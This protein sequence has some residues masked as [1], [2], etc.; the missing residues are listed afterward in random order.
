ETPPK[1]VNERSARIYAQGHPYSVTLAASGPS[2]LS[3]AERSVWA[4]A[5]YA[6]SPALLK[7]L[8]NKSQ[9]DV[10]KV[11]NETGGLPLRAPR[12]T[13]SWGRDRF[14][15]DLGEYPPEQFAKRSERTLQLAALEVQRRAFLAKRERERARWVDPDTKEVVAVS[16]EEIEE[17]RLR[18]SEIA[19]LRMELY[20]E[21]SGAYG[22]DPDWDDVVPMPVEDGEG[23]LAAIAYPDD[24]AEAISYLR[25]VMAK[26]EYSPRCLRL[27]EHIISLNPAHYTVWLYRFSIVE[28]LHLPLSEEIEWLNKVSLDNLKNYQIWHHRRLLL[29]H[30][31][32]TIQSSPEKTAELARSEQDFL[33]QILAEDTKNYHVWSYR[34]YM[35]PKLGIFGA[36]EIKAAEDLIDDDVRNNSAWSHRFF[37][38]FSDPEH[39][40]PGSLPT[41]HDLAVPADIIDREIQY[42]QD[43][44]LLAPQNQSPWNYLRGVLVK[45]GRKMSSVEAFVGQ[46]V[47]GAGAD[48]DEEEK[49]TSTH[50]LEMLAEIYAEKGE[51]DKADWCLRRLGEKWDRIRLGYWQWKRQMLKDENVSA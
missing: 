6:R 15:A 22:T 18:R 40:T 27:T 34:Q 51:V 49:V 29:D 35:V 44:I 46:F 37:V 8:G 12:T 19:T 33:T 7:Q 2:G 50:G 23:T 4:N 21:R 39:T 20:G 43:K 11:V 14:G 16:H 42:A 47:S 13:H 17:E 28:A 24:Y 48:N 41:D 10:W 30:Y 36:S 32:P 1:T 9:R 3:P 38:V 45:G 5:H 26:K 31:F 25:A